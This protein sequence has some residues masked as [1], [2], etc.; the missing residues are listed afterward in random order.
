MKNTKRC[1]VTFSFYDRTGIKTYLE[2]QAENG[3]LLNKIS[4]FGW[5]FRRIE[6]KKIHFSVVYFSKASAFDPE[7]SKDQLEFQDFCEHTGWKLAA[8]NAQM[9]IFY[10]ETDYPIPI[11]TDASLEISAIHTSAKKN[12]LLSYYLLTGVGILQA[13]LFFWRLFSDPISVLA[14]NASLFSGLCWLLMLI[15]SIIEIQGYFRWYKR[16]KNAAE[17]DGSFVE[18]KGHHNYQVIILCIMLLAF[19]FLLISYGGS[20]MT[21]I[22]L[23][24]IIVIFGITVIIVCV[25]ELM[26]RLKVSAKI[27]RN[28]TIILTLVLS[29]GFAG[30]LLI[31]IIGRI[32]VL[33]PEKK[34]VDTYEFRGF[35]Q[36]IYHDELPLTI[37][38]L[39]DTDYDRY[40][41]E[42]ITL[43]QSI[44]MEQHVA[45]QRPR[46]DHLEKPDLEYTI[47]NIHVLPLYDWCKSALLNDF[48]HNYGHPEP[49]DSTWKEHVEI[50]A[51]S[52]KANEVY[53]L[54]LGGEP[55]MRF[56]LCYDHRIIEIDF[57]HDWELT[58]EQMTIVGEKLNIN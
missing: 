13:V 28:I 47:T 44:L 46:M 19:A 35:T 20:R 50:D 16:A 3:W 48:A 51:S 10:N 1:M 26:K 29:F 30:M 7:P 49:S 6:P 25:S 23:T 8:S 12:Y 53:Q 5:I 36:N 11:E 24:A 40:S 58:P 57:E 39:I 34:T 54:I 45:I 56:L 52:W 4:A 42:L 33:Y 21:L 17:I 38:D 9:Q 31:N 32:S 27:N 15:I 37:E 55:Q 18:T 14:S 43:N 2:K 22:A 41:Y